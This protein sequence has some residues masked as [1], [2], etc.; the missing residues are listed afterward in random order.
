MAEGSPL[1][2]ESRGAVAELSVSVPRLLVIDASKTGGKSAT[3]QLKRNFLLGW[4]DDAFLQVCAPR[5]DGFPLAR[6][7][8]DPSSVELAPD[9]RAVYREVAAFNPDVIYYRPTIDQHARLYE[10]AVNVM[11]RQP[12][13]LVSHLM[14]DWLSRLSASDP[15]RW[16]V[17]DA[18]LRRLLD[19]SQKVLSISEKMSRIYG[20]RYGVTFEPIANGVDP[21]TYRDASASAAPV[22]RERKEVV[23]RYTGALAKDMTFQTVL[24]VAR[25]VDSLCAELPL[26]F[27]IYT[28]TAWRPAFEE[29]AAGLRG[30]SVHDGVFGS[31]YP[32]LLTEADVLVLAYNFDEDSIRYVSLSVPNKLPEYLAS[33]A[34]ML[35]VG[36]P[37][38]NG[39][40]YVL[41]RQLGSCVTKRDPAEL[42]AA[43]RRL[44]DGD[45]YREELAARAQSY[46]FEHLDLGRISRRFQTILKEAARTST[47]QADAPILGPFSRRGAVAESSLNPSTG[48]ASA[49]VLGN[50]PSLRDVDLKAFSGVTTIG[51]NAAYRHWERIGWYP[52]HYC[53]LDEE[54]IASHHDAIQSLLADGRVQTAFVT[55]RILDFHPEL[56]ENERCFF[57]DSFRKTW[58]TRRGRKWGL[59]F[60][61]HPAF[62]TSAPSKLTTGAYAVRYAIFL[63]HRKIY[64]LGIDC[65]YVD[66]VEGAKGVG[67]DALEMAR[68][69]ESNPNYFFDDYQQAGDRYNL[70]SPPV[71]GGNLHL[72][73][74]EALRDDVVEQ[75]LPVEIRNCSAASKLASEGIF[76]FEERDR[77]L[78]KPLLGAVAV[79]MTLGE[80]DSL[81]A[82]LRSWNEPTQIPRFPDADGYAVPLVVV[83]NGQPETEFETRVRAV[84]NRCERLSSSFSSLHFEYCR[85]TK[86]DDRYERD[87]TKR[88]G[89]GGFKSG[90]NAQFF[91]SM[92]LLRGYGRYV[93]MME[94][95]CIAIRPNWLGELERIVEG[96]EP[97]WVMGSLYRGVGRINE[98]Y[99]LHINGNA[100]YAV[101]DEEF[102]AFLADVWRP[103]MET[104]VKQVRTLAYDCVLPLH[105][106]GEAPAPEGEKWSLY[107]QIA[108]RFRY[109]EF[110]QSHASKAEL[111]HGEGGSL[112]HIR[113]R[114]PRTYILHGKHL[115]EH[116]RR[117]LTWSPRVLGGAPPRADELIE[118]L[119]A[120]ET[121][122]EQ[123]KSGLEEKLAELQS[124][125]QQMTDALQAMFSGTQS[126]PRPTA[127]TAA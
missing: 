13:P 101:G 90:P 115:A 117:S 58:H 91:G 49:F 98:R 55:A 111:E 41:S 119:S 4:P 110:I 31:G 66:V 123:L 70:P 127:N 68:T 2:A 107:Q 69:P 86:R 113:D 51:M 9:E 95:D 32:K 20:E 93:F 106:T 21:A 63:G 26:R 108:H 8:S 87:Y 23:L 22:K 109:T 15:A 60:M 72:Q 125:L 24:D 62:Q 54:L 118:T 10:V 16:E 84:F 39:I 83:L 116:A 114:S 71:H 5:E 67:G 82:N 94:T 7:L 46:A 35:A 6:S 102:Q 99:R 64:L 17:A 76:P 12:V 73:S 25:A 126:Q 65:N 43:I 56:A 88:A 78:P 80:E 124:E 105:F 79:P 33:G 122:Q 85:L 96:S 61:K 112:E 3:G 47:G 48:P 11:A 40:E 103:A 29:A 59:P 28:M 14:D 53:C 30:V 81:L 121:D 100:V 42:A 92:E 38:A 89:P 120:L 57:L 52:T 36:P 104:L 97:F 45:E 50:G 44:A 27:E 74:L 19:R 34:A 1:L 75:G 77:A 37:E 18:E